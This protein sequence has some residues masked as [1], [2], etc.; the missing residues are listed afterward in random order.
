MFSPVL[1][2]EMFRV[3]TTGKTTVVTAAG[4][5]DLAVSGHLAALLDR[6]IRLR[7]RAFLIDTT[8]VTFCG[9]RAVDLLLDASRCAAA[10]GV[11]FALAGRSR[12]VVRPI[13]ALGLERALPV[14]RS[15]ADA[16]A[17]LELL[18]RLARPS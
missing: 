10:A 6:E 9:A 15:T 18:P 8:A 11:P 4:D 12:A 13:T 16:L 14:H 1:L 5:L 17:W 7:P 3:T 2:S